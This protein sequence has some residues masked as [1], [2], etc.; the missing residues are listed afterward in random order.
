MLLS[1]YIRDTGCV[2]FIFNAI[3]LAFMYILAWEIYKNIIP[4]LKKA[5]YPTI[6]YKTAGA[7]IL[8]LVEPILLFTVVKIVSDASFLAGEGILINI[9]IYIAIYVLQKAVISVPKGFLKSRDS[10]LTKCILFFSIIEMALCLFVAIKIDGEI[11][12]YIYLMEMLIMSSVYLLLKIII[13]LYEQNINEI[14]ADRL[15]NQINK[16]KDYL[17][18]VELLDKQLKSIKHDINIQLQVL[19]DLLNSQKYEEAEMY[20]KSCGMRIN[21]VRDYVNT[22]NLLM[23]KV[24]NSKIEYAKSNNIVV[25]CGIHKNVKC[26]SGNSLSI[27]LGNMLDNAI[28]AELKENEDDREIDI[29]SFWK[30]DSMIL[31]VSNYVSQSVFNNNKDLITT[32]EDSDHHG[33]GLKNIKYLIEESGGLLDCYEEN[34]KFV[35]EV[36]W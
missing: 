7:V 8:F 26:I 21:R 14:E 34:D 13:R 22:D 24:I 25:T 35:C 32:K 19:A 23:N 9:I 30:G 20:L 17:D 5:K 31:R 27:I 3:G 29:S 33:I 6:I 28:E 10:L 4:F 2:Y 16:N 11:K 15:R 12:I 36:I 18:N 1:N